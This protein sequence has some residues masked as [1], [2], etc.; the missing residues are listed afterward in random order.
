MVR[1]CPSPASGLRPSAPSPRFTGRGKIKVRRVAIP[2]LLVYIPSHAHLDLT[3]PPP[4]QRPPRPAAGRTRAD[5]ADRADGAAADAA[6][7]A[8]GAVR[9]DRIRRADDA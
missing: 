9:A 5:R 7:R 1:D 8:D 2:K 6:G 4:S 3:L